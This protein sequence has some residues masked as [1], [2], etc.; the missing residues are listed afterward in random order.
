MPSNIGYILMK[1]YIRYWSTQIKQGWDN[2]MRKRS[3]NKRLLEILT[4][5]KVIANDIKLVQERDINMALNLEALTAEVSRVKTVQDSAI[6]LL[7]QLGDAIKANVDDPAA[8]NKIV[9]DLKVSTDALA[10]AVATST[11]AAPTT[12]VILHA[13]D[14]TTPTVKVVLPEVLPEVVKVDA[15]VVVPSVDP[16]S[17]EPQVVVTVE[18]A[19]A[20]V[21]EAVEAAPAAEVADPAVTVPSNEGELV[22]DVIKTDEGQTDV[23]VAAPAEVHEEVKAE[24]GVDI[25][26]SVKEAFEAVPEV[27]AAP[28]AP[29]EAPVEAP[30]EEAKP[31][32]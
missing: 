4:M 10:A 17:T 3:E 21:A 29:A 9:D 12:E 1:D 18:P 25:V 8:L 32:E 20:A 30:A 22:T 23:V 28:E 15:E 6:V 24:A 31:A 7:K 2:L 19:P 11:V 13:D 26:E 27:V 14:P 16:A 5:L